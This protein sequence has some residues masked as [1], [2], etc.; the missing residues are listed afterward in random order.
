MSDF[1]KKN[2]RKITPRTIN[3]GPIKRDKERWVL[4]FLEGVQHCLLIYCR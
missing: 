1:R 3:R 2:N 4:G